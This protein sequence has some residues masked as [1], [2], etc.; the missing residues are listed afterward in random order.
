V[1]VFGLTG[2]L[3]SGKGVVSARFAARGLPVINADDLARD[4]V[5][6]GTPGLAA[7]VAEFGADVVD[8]R[9]ELDRR[10][11]AQRVFG[12]PEARK[13]LEAITHPRIGAAMLER[14][15]EL[16]RRGEAL[17]CYEAPLLVEIGR[18][19]ALRPL[20]VVAAST[21]TQVARA[22]QRDALPEAEVRA[23]IAAQLPLADK[24]RVADYVIEND[25]TLAAT[26]AEADRVLDAICARFSLPPERYPRPAT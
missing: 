24:V 4:V 20:V 14:V 3:A 18:A 26:L 16:G 19:D 2:G 13:R 6:P 15:A 1:H 9:G 21:E 25:G 12:E 17:A 10:R 8:T 5:Q 11:L 7:V 22:M 23:R